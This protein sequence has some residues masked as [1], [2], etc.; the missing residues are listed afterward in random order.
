MDE[1]ETAIFEPSFP[2]SWGAAA[3]VGCQF[4]S[5]ALTATTNFV[6]NIQVRLAA[7]TNHQIDQRT[8]RDQVA[9]DIERIIEE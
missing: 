2:W 1:E 3:V 5:E 7:A 6:D 9:Q 4:L 8:F